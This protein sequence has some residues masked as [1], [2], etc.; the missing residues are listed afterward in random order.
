MIDVMKTSMHR[1]AR[2][3]NWF[4]KWCSS[5]VSNIDLMRYLVSFVFKWYLANHGAKDG[6]SN[7]NSDWYHASKVHSLHL[8]I[9]W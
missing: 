1:I 3:L 5:L 4:Y 6:V 8:S 2:H 7:G 9:I